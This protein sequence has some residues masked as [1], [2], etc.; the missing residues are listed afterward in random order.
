MGFKAH[1]ARQRSVGWTID[2]WNVAN[3]LL[4]YLD[5]EKRAYATFTRTDGSYVQCAG[6]KRRVTVEARVIDARGGFEPSPELCGQ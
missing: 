1:Y 2:S 5:P 3:Q 4:S 6:A